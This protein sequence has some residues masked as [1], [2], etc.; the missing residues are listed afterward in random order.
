[1]PENI[2]D[3]PARYDQN[4]EYL[5]DPMNTQAKPYSTKQMT[6]NQSHANKVWV[7]NEDGGKIVS[8]EEAKKLLSDGWKDSPYA[9]PN[10][11]KTE[12]ENVGLKV[13]KR[14]G[15]KKLKDEL[16]KASDG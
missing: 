16:L 6:A 7:Y 10:A 3:T 5:R 12:A 13:D 9:H 4:N 14:W 15:A 11:L 8:L 1:M 2:N